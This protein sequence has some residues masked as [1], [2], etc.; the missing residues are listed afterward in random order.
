ME[1]FY[2]VECILILVII[3]DFFRI[4]GK[5]AKLLHARI[6]VFSG[7]LLIMIYL[8]VDIMNIDTSMITSTNENRSY[9]LVFLLT[10]LVFLTLNAITL[11]RDRKLN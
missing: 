10:M 7:I 2:L 8:I 9:Y 1:L 3:F 11:W 6:V 4:F 5:I